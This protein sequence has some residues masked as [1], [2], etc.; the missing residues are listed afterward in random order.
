MA[1]KIQW[2][3]ETWNCITG[4]TQLSAGC[5][6]CYAKKNA[7]RMRENPNPK[8]AYK[9]RN[10]FDLTI[11]P[12]YL[13]LPRTWHKPRK[14]FVNSMS[15]TFHRD[16]PEDF[17]SEIFEVIADC[18]QH[19]F[20]VLTKRA[21]RLAE[22]SPKLPWPKNLWIGVTVENADYVDRLECLRSV[23]A[24][25]RFVSFEPLL[26]RIPHIDLTGIHQVIVGG[27]SGSKA[28]L[29]DLQWARDIRDQCLENRVPFFFKQVGG[30]DRHKGG[31]LL[32][33]HEWNEFPVEI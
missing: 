2:T 20:Q 7:L 9:Y 4:C 24:T 30:R 13:D 6:N 22:L 14:I 31:R 32:D 18:P 11:H 21:E 27:E 25:I 26:S 28:R 17:I 3:D 10:G 16:V 8:T 12:D 29:M 15:D 1:T 5:A 23:P 19:I 33:G